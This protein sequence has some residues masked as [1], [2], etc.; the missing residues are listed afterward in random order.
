MTKLPKIF[1]NN[2]KFFSNNKNSYNTYNKISEKK[3]EEINNLSNFDKNILI[4]YFN[5]K[6][7]ITLKNGNKVS[8]ILI[9]KRNDTILLDSGEYIHVNDINDIN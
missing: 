5:K 9:S 3:Y 4:N 8:G 6:I 2:E 7:N 1:R